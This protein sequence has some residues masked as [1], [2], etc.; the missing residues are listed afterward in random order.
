M[1]PEA[2]DVDVIR[3]LRSATV[4]TEDD[5]CLFV[6][7]SREV[8]VA[9]GLERESLVSAITFAVHDHSGVSSELRTVNKV[10]GLS[11]VT[12]VRRNI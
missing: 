12:G 8:T 1:L 7:I 6:A 3:G 5:D 4:V 9:C 2:I 11:V 10:D